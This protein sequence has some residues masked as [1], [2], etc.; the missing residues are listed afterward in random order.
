MNWR[1]RGARGTSRASEGRPCVPGWYPLLCAEVQ[2]TKARSTYRELET[3]SS[4]GSVKMCASAVPKSRARVRSS[5]L[6]RSLLRLPRSSLIPSLTLT[7]AH[8]LITHD[9]STPF[10]LCATCLPARN[11]SDTT[12]ATRSPD[13]HSTRPTTQLARWD[14]PGAPFPT[15]SRLLSSTLYRGREGV[16]TASVVFQHSSG[17]SIVCFAPFLSRPPFVFLPALAHRQ[18]QL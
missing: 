18:P 7:L 2:D 1:R 8:S 12:G 6:V 16:S 10:A 4:G 17:S 15:E 14:G 3:M 5:H 13:D 11:T 9:P